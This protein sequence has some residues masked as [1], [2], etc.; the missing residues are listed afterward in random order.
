MA[1]RLQKHITI[2]LNNDGVTWTYQ[3]L[4]INEDSEVY[5]V[6]RSLIL[7]NKSTDADY[8]VKLI[9]YDYY[10]NFGDGSE[11]GDSGLYLKQDGQ[12]LLQTGSGSKYYR[13][14]AKCVASSTDN[15]PQLIASISDFITLRK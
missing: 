13:L 8:Q 3:D 9:P 11:A 14:G 1:E 4:A 15:P 7:T 5:D 6:P 12:L 10:T 2:A